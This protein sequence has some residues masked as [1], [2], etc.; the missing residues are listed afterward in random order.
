LVV[1]AAIAQT[2]AKNGITI[3]AGW[4]HS[5]TMTAPGSPAIPAAGV[6]CCCSWPTLFDD[7]SVGLL[8]GVEVSY[9]IP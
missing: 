9:V 8:E 6:G 2:L 4:A 3:T 7:I 5:L 1:V